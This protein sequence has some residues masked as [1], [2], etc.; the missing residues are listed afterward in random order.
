MPRGTRLTAGSWWPADYAG[1]P[2]V[3]VDAALAKGL[4]LAIGDT[5]TLNA[6][7]RD[8]TARVANLRQVNWL[9]LSIN[10]V[11][12]FSPGSLDGL[13]M[14]T[15]ETVRDK[16]L[17]KRASSWRAADWEAMIS[18]ARATIRIPTS[19]RDLVAAFTVR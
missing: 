4:G 14:A 5:V 16:V 13:P 2:L 11:F 17:T 8:I 3:S 9:G 6:L 12:V 15:A 18:S 19:P 1:S 10:F 7:G